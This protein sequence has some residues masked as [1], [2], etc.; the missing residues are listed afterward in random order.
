MK[1]AIIFAFA[2]FVLFTPVAV[3]AANGNPGDTAAGV[4]ITAEGFNNFMRY[5][6]AGGA[7]MTIV[8]TETIIIAVMPVYGFAGLANAAEGI[9]RKTNPLVSKTYTYLVS[10]EGNKADTYTLDVTRVSYHGCVGTGWTIL[11]SNDAFSQSGNSGSIGEDATRKVYVTVIP[12]DQDQ[13]PNGSWVLVTLEVYTVQTPVGVYTG[14][15][16]NTY[17]GTSEAYSSA[18]T[19]IEASLMSI[20]R[21]FEV[22]APTEYLAGTPLGT[23]DAVPGAVITY[24]ITVTN[25]GGAAANSIVIIDH[26]PVSTEAAHMGCSV[27][28][29]DTI[30]TSVVTITVPEP[31]A[32]T[33][34]WIAYYSTLTAP[35]TTYEGSATGGWTAVTEPKSLIGISGIKWIKWE[36]TGV[37]DKA[38]SFT[39]GV[40]IR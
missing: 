28:G 25:E 15:N 38:T 22:D 39:W 10:N 5:T 14:A 23:H 1:K 9:Y 33:R 3:F 20:S 6:D 29:Q 31:N 4:P 37:T 40:T 24:K 27:A 18:I 11:T 13:A 32:A 2:A 17:G 26:V 35:A 7:P 16:A 8:S 34:G 19:S 21:T 36:N 30:S 12:G